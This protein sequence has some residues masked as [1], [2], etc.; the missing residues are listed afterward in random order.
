[1]IKA[2]FIGAFTS[3]EQLPEGNSCE[4]AIAGRSNCGKSSLINALTE[5]KKLA[6]TSSTPGRTQT[7]NFFHVTINQSPS[8]FLVDLPGYGYAQ[9]SREQKAAWARFV[10]AYIDKRNPLKGMFV[11]SDIRRDISNDERD[12]F[13]WGLARGF[14]MSLVLTKSDKVSKHERTRLQKHA[15]TQLDPSISTHI[16]SIHDG[17]S[18]HALRAH[19]LKVISPNHVLPK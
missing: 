7:I 18:I 17:P 8:F 11:L 14:A 2:E 10:T 4:I 13:A 3:L 19:L 9:V 6:H 12:L 15:A 1:M 16:V 5:R